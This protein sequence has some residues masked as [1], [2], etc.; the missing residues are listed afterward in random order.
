MRA[1]MVVASLLVAAPAAA[2]E[3][4]GASDY[5]VERLRLSWDRE[6]VLTAESAWVPEHLSWDLGLWVGYADDPLIV[7]DTTTGDRVGSIVGSRAGAALQGSVALLGWMEVGLELPLVLSQDGSDTVGGEMG[8]ALSGGGFGDARLGV[9]VR[10]LQASKAGVD[11]AVVP[12]FTFPTGG[13][14]DYLGDG[15]LTFTPEVAVSRGFGDAR[16]AANVG[17]RL[18]EGTGASLLRVD[19]EVFVD[20]GGGYRIGKAD[21]GAVISASLSAVEPSDS[22][23]A[24]AIELMGMGGYDVWGPVQAFAGAGVGVESAYGVPDWRVFVG[25]RYT[26]RKEKKAI[27][28][29]IIA[30]VEPVKD[31]EP[32]KE[33]EPE[34]VKEPEPPVDNDPDK[35]TVMN[36]DDK[37]PDVAGP[38]E[39]LGCPDQDR[40]G[41]TV[42]DRLDN[43]PD[44]AGDPAEQGCVKK[45]LVQIQTGSLVI[46]DVIYFKK[47]SDVIERKS[48]KLLKNLAQV[49]NSHP[50][51]TKIRIEG[52]TSEEGSSE[53]NQELSQKRAESVKAFLVKEGVAEDR[54]EPVGFGETVPVADN[55]THA[56][57]VKNRRVEFKIAEGVNAEGAGDAPATQ[58]ATP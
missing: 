53:R 43:C 44:E 38:V 37:C 18:R 28:P 19:D 45:Q 33:P 6:G 48:H 56:G 16:V 54:L 12:S 57:R 35:D 20:V 3:W 34:P 42:V 47:G 1:L 30:S 24:S 40:D 58:P 41:D 22:A 32:I 51:I 8:P 13:G 26:M 7:Y 10:V 39:N 50:N 5:G 11:V 21:V 2:Q 49:I 31:P 4:A 9:K 27:P 55:K 46:L 15:G 36:P 29:E 25:A 52:H 14:E 17:Y 23:N